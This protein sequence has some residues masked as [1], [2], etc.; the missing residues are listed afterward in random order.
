LTENVSDVWSRI[1]RWLEANARDLRASLA[2]PASDQEIAARE[3]KLGVSLPEDFKAAYRIHNGQR[4]NAPGLTE[5][6]EL[7][8]LK[9]VVEEWTTWKELLDAGDFAGAT[10]EPDAGV[11]NEWWSPRRIPFTY[12]GAGNHLCVDLEPAAGGRAGQV[13]AMW[14]DDPQRHLVAPSFAEWLAALADGLDGGEL[15]Y[16][17]RAGGIVPAGDR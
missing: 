6:G 9:I 4:P 5:L 16:S 8:P 1:E 7:L 12:D 17:K 14:H 11:R 3:A 2:G 10:S 13:I 15:V